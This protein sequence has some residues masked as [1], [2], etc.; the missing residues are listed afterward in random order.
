[1]SEAPKLGFAAFS[2]RP[3][4]VLVLFCDEGL[5]F[6]AAAREALAPS[7]DLMS[8]AA[9]AD[10]FTGKIG[11]ALDLVAPAGLDVS[12]LIV[13][14]AGKTADLKSRELIKLGGTALGRI[15]ASA[16]QA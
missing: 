6:G 5:K 15:P 3:K 12:R 14:G 10:R 7:G 13:L 16:T 9:A 1:M 4:G 11:T 2:A 8:R